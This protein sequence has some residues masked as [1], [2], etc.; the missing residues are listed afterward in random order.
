[1]KKG[2]Y[3]RG[4]SIAADNKSTV[5]ANTPS[6]TLHADL[7]PISDGNGKGFFAK[8]FPILLIILLTAGIYHVNFDNELTNWDDDK[9]IDQN[10]L[11]KDFS[12]D[13]VYRMFF[14]TNNGERYFMGNY[15]PL[16]MLT[17]N[18]D[19]HYSDLDSC[20]KA[21]PARF[22]AVNIILHLLT[23][24]FIYLICCQLFKRRLYSVIIPLIF[25]VHTL[26]VESVTWISERKDVLYA[27]FYFCALWLYIIYKKKNNIVLYICSLIVFILSALSKGQAVSLTLSVV[28][29]DYFLTDNY[30]NWKTHLNKI[31]YLLISLVF[32]L[33]SIEAQKASTA[34]SEVD[35]YYFYQRIAL[36]SYGFV[37][38]ILRLILPINLANLYPYP[39]IIN[40]T[41]PSLY[42]LAVPVF[43]GAI[44]LSV[45]TYKK[46][47]TL[48]FG[49]LFFIANIALLLQFIPVGSA[50][51]SDRYSYIPSFGTG[52]LLAYLV[53]ILL[54]K[55]KINKYLIYGAVSI[56][57]L[58]LSLM[59]VERIKVWKNSE[60]LWSDC[61][62][63]YPEAVIGW[64]NL[65]SYINVMADSLYKKSN[66]SK[67]IEQKKYAV[68]CFTQGLKY[69]P[70]YT[71]AFYN[72]GLANKDLFDATQDTTY[73]RQ[74]LEDYT[75]ALKF[76][77]SFAAAF[78]NR[79]LIYDS[80]G[81]R[82]LSKNKD[83]ANFYFNL[84]L[85][86]YDR[87]LETN[88]NLWDIYINRGACYGKSGRLERALEEL[89]T[90]IRHDTTNCSAYSNRGLAFNGLG[91]YQEALR[92]FDKALSLDSTM[93]GAY[94]NK[95]ITLRQLG[96]LNEAVEC[97]D[98]L[99]RI[100]PENAQAYYYRGV[101]KLG[102]NNRGGGCDDLH[103]ALDLKYM[104]A[105]EMILR[106]C[107][108]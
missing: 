101:Y 48:T 44:L 68:D 65:G 64:N 91:Q 51:Y 61:V 36:G 94:F 60:T 17:L 3:V 4:T 49:V 37:Q 103:K 5:S 56:Y 28:L 32:G 15:H 69:K 45:F 22:I 63:K 70:D 87:A 62:S 78:Q 55:K 84:A 1:M 42:W 82:W 35:Q 30:F 10:P 108:Q 19:Y 13:A 16:T 38:Y 83:T 21:K 85:S 90:Y 57:V 92:D 71:H 75:N 25:A 102:L 104:P 54:N 7:E 33:I 96:K 76:D 41:V 29:V 6:P 74:A 40:R 23:V 43:V 20:G 50:M 2:R 95:S 88:P 81:E 100:H 18:I 14:S 52:V 26:H 99:I 107:N 46:D 73:E 98:K 11:L 97:L 72:R 24:L 39:D 34:L 59:T 31:P 93:E 67:F 8:H 79:A 12:G 9:Y 89:Q 66:D 106:Y 27:M 47:K 58:S 77:L 105:Q 86:D 80:Y 53:D